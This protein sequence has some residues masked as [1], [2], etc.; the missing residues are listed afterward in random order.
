[1]TGVVVNTL[2][3]FI[4]A[5]LGLVFRSRIP[6]KVINAIMVAVGLCVLSI[7]IS[8]SLGGQNAV[9]SIISMVLGTGIGELLDI[10][11]KLNKFG[12]N[13]SKKFKNNKSGSFS[14]GFVTASLVFCVGSM[15]IVGGLNAGL[16]G[17]NTMLFTKSLLDFISS[18][19]FTATL[20]I[21]VMLSAVSIFLYQGA[22]VLFAG[23]IEPYLTDF[24]IAELNCVGSL[25][26]LALGLN[27]IGLSKF[28]V[29]NFLPALIFVPILCAIVEKLAF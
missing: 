28:K 14:E 1:M 15:A 24:V 10:E 19:M 21:G 22:I 27:I 7:G 11:E 16:R 26:V 13:V 20:G 3:V 6:Q 18:I 8:G 9:V 25:M 4:G 5:F 23:F 12:D 29:A 2:A 17:D